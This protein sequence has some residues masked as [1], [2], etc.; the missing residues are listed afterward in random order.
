LSTYKL[1]YASLCLRYLKDCQFIAT[2][3]DECFPFNHKMLPDTGSF[4]QILITATGKQ[5]INV[6]K[7]ETFLL[8]YI[9]EKYKLDRNRMCMIGDRLDTD[10]LMGLNG[11]LKTVVVFTGVTTEEDLKK[12]SILPHYVISSLEEAY[13]LLNTDNK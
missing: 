3:K 5:P 6:G 4:L 1:G 13:K 11:K 7:P 8:D 10:V 2:N 12:S 9:V